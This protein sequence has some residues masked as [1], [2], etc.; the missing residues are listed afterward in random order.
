MKSSNNQIIK[1]SDK[2]EQGQTLIV[3]VLAIIVIFIAALFLF[4]LQS[5]IRVKV[6][7]QTA[8]DAAALAGA[9]SQVKSLNLI[10]EINIIKACTV[11]VSD[12]AGGHDTEDELEAA[13]D[14]LTEMQARITFV[15]PLLGIGAAQQAA[16][17]NG[18][19]A[20]YTLSRDMNDYLNNVRDDTI[21][22]NE[23][24]FKPVIEGYRWREPY[25]EMLQVLES[26]G[27]VAAP[28][29]Y[30]AS[31]ND[32]FSDSSLYSAIMT[33][34]WCHDGLRRLLKDD[35]NFVGPWWHGL[36]GSVRFI[37]ESELMPLYVR[38]SSGT[39]TFNDAGHYLDLLA[40]DRK[41]KVSDLYDTDEPEDRDNINT[42]I[43]YMRWCSY[44]FRWYTEIPGNH[45][46]E[47]SRCL[48]LRRGIRDEY[49][50]G[51]A[52]SAFRCVVNEASWL[53][54]SYNVHNISNK[55][56]VITASESIP[57]E[58]EATAAAK[59]LGYL[60]FNGSRVPPN[61]IAMILPVFH[62]AR[63]TPTKLPPADHSAI[64]GSKEWAIYKFLLWCDT[65]GDID[66]PQTDPPP[67]SENYLL[68]FQKLNDPLWRHSGWN[69]SYSYSP[70]GEVVL[71]DPNSDTGAG[72]LQEPVGNPNGGEGNDGYVYDDDGNIIGI[73][74][75]QDDLCDWGPSGGRPGSGGGGP[76][77][78]H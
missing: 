32:M 8:A 37:E 67:G 13:S 30:T 26:Q 72:F 38:Y 10:G 36:V 23:E 68:A 59:P 28:Q 3:A 52:Y 4:D 57:P 49:I 60:E 21:Y 25:I 58:V 77:S 22:G 18:M 70:P 27:M 42:P 12:F 43:P 56:G 74:Y 45:W 65:V 53:S 24:V 64:L 7:T 48:Y 54:G 39:A 50:Y 29:T 14:N 46:T 20:Y 73:A 17:N 78:L 75:T 61:S 69:P 31:F 35:S 63:L 71:Y 15:G 66:D 40:A 5:I 2:R 55:R 16:K 44:D 47:G 6:K 76:G 62:S 51:G 34:F 1:P 9:K 41:L 11:L 33:N 19:I